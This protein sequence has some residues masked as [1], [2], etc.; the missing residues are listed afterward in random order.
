MLPTSSKES[1]RQLASAMSVEEDARGFEE[2]TVCEE[3]DGWGHSECRALGFESRNRAP[4]VRALAASVAV[5]FALSVMV[6]IGVSAS[7]HQHQTALAQN[8]DLSAQLQA[9]KT[10]RSGNDPM[11]RKAK[12][13]AEKASAAAKHL[14]EE[15]NK[16]AAFF[17]EAAKAERAQAQAAKMEEVSV[18]KALAADTAGKTEEW[19]R[20][21]HREK[22]LEEERKPL[23]VAAWK[24]AQKARFQDALRV[25]ASKADVAS[26]NGLTKIAQNSSMWK[27]TKPKAALGARVAL[28]ERMQELEN[29]IKDADSN[30]EEDAVGSAGTARGAQQLKK[31]GYDIEV[32]RKLLHQCK[33][34]HG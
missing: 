8:R 5:I 1:R 23:S 17:E 21:V 11:L 34:C 15:S 26:L 20:E 4:V 25:R 28:A 7:K 27:D 13:L 9:S 10:D 2:L 16:A 30:T 24:A 22:N 19:V 29:S 32:V 12:P 14:V 3:E 31:N 33:N 6:A 18:N